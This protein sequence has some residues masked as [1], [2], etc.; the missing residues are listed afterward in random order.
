MGWYCGNVSGNFACTFFCQGMLLV[1]KHRTM[2][3]DESTKYI[4]IRFLFMY[5]RM[6]DTSKFCFDMNTFIRK[7]FL[8]IFSFRKNHKQIS[9]F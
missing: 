4:L 2:F 6:L 1:C 3:A 7:L 5:R 9:S 8:Q